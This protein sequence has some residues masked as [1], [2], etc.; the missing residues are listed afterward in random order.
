MNPPLTRRSI[1]RSGAAAAA[2]LVVGVPRPLR[3]AQ[4]ELVFQT[5]G[6]WGWGNE[7]QRRVATAMGRVAEVQGCDFILSVG[8]NFYP[9]GVAGIDDAK[10]RT[11]FED[12]YTAP[13]LQ[14]PWHVALGNHDYDGEVQAQIDYTARSWR[15]RMPSHYFKRS[16]LL[17]DGTTVDFFVTD[18]HPIRRA[19]RNWVRFVYFPPAEQVEW[20]GRELAA[21]RADWKIVVG[22]HPVYSGGRH[23]NTDGLIEQ[24]VPLFKQYGVQ[25]YLNGHNHNLEHVVVDGIHYLTS[26][27]ASQP[28][29]VATVPGSQF[30]F[31]GLGFMNARLSYDSLVIE[32][33][34]ADTKPLHRATIR[35]AAGVARQDQPIRWGR[36]ETE[37]SQP[38]IRRVNP[39]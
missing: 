17:A 35:R 21:S 14:V 38:P 3:A 7:A 23:G 19:Y 4:N 25:A 2:A 28:R 1:L 39:V 30:A 33:F 37:R 26:G 32:F 5:L 16:E 24:F 11:H 18:T 20:L 6:D 8:D 12:I 27:A 36:V 10:W 29:P 34:D 13:A 9:E 22:H 15:W 31:S